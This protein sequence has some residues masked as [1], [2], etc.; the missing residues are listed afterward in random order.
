MVVLVVKVMEV[1]AASVAL[2]QAAFV[3]GTGELQA[4]GSIRCIGMAT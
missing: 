4:I 1:F 2:Q 3:A